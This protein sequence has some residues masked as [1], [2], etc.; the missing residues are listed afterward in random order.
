MKLRAATLLAVV[1]IVISAAPA[2]AQGDTP[3]ASLRLL[4]QTAWTTPIDPVLK[5]GLQIHNDSAAAIAGLEIRWS[6]GSKIGARDEYEQALVDGVP[7]PTAADTRFLERDLGAGQTAEV[8]LEIDTS[9]HTAIDQGDSGVYPLQIDL[10]SEEVSLASLTTAA[11]HIAQEPLAPLTFSWWTDVDT[12]VAFAPSGELIDPRFEEALDA[13]TGVVAQVRSIADAL[14]HPK[15]SSPVDLVVA[16]ATLEQ[17]EQAADGYRRQDGTQVP[18]DA[19]GAVAAADTLRMLRTIAGDPDARL[20]A[21]PFAAPRLPALVSSILQ[22]ELGEQWRVGDA[23]F[24]RLLGER[25]DTS[26]ARPPGLALDDRSLEALADRGVSTILGAPDS[27][28]RET[29][30][31]GLA[32][33][34]AAVV[35]TGSGDRLDILLPDPSTEA[36]IVDRD[37]RRDPVLA[38][39]AV[40]GELA[41]IWRELPVPPDPQV[42]GIAL[43]LPRDLPGGM[44]APIVSRLTRAPFLDPVHA[45]R[46][47]DAIDPAPAPA[48]LATRPR[49]RFSPAYVTDLFE[50]SRDVTAFGSLV[51]EPTTEVSQLR[52]QILYAESAQYVG[53]EI[54]GRS[55]IDAVN[56]VTDPTFEALAP[57]TSRVLTF[58]SR[59]GRIPLRMGDP[60]DRIVRVS[61]ELRSGRVDFPDAT[62]TVRLDRAN[63]VVTFDAEVKA[64]GRS[65]IEV[66]VSAPDGTVLTKSVLVIRSTALNPI[67]LIITGVAGL[68]LVGLWSRRLFRRRTG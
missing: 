49:G 41:T 61:V 24:E 59:S 12:P 10:L 3:T 47:P 16:P 1:A 6:L 44:W 53:D 34:P 52:R 67:A 20:S 17:L 29:G 39:Q 57:D 32:P 7:S 22:P 37:L 27:V 58:T 66:T 63:Q 28:A 55:W 8:S 36:L 48:D 9:A 33:P 40:L 30:P 31:L 46:L 13:G 64:A 26:V 18:A 19:P 65:S 68:V 2:R 54:A 38:A 50:T 21:T 51:E 11:I 5:I 56:G 35:T 15:R 25:P 60:G 45:E 62:R 42:R 14:A 4:S 23:T 43:E